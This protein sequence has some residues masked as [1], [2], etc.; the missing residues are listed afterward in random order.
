[1]ATIW[2]GQEYLIN[3]SVIDDNTEYDKIIPVI[4]LVQDKYVLPLLGTSLYNTMNTHI[5]N[6]INNLT[7]IPTAYA[8]LLNDY[9]LKMLVH[10]IMYES[11]PT[12]KYRYVNKG[13]MINSSDNGQPISQGEME[14]Q[15]NIWKT[16]AEMYADRMIKYLNYNNNSYP[17][18][19]TNTGADI[20]PDRQSYEVDIYLGQRKRGEK[21]YS[22]IV[23]LKD[24]P[25]WL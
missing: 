21:D 10:F 1:M 17:S 12:F 19:N 6:Y 8:T 2:I 4:I 9:I 14:F 15:M 7:V 22:N 5:E 13:I 16:N 20:F 24:N 18:Y 11:S 23:N 3:N 25:E